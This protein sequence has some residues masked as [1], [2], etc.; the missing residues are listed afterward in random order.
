MGIP[1]TRVVR[2]VPANNTDS[3]SEM[4]YVCMMFGW[5]LDHLPDEVCSYMWMQFDSNK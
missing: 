5:R 3:F 1:S 2:I 4:L